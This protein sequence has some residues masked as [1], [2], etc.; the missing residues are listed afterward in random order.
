MLNESIEFITRLRAG[1]H[2]SSLAD[3]VD[4]MDG[5]GEPIGW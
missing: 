2:C 4:Q 1:L 5:R 3:N